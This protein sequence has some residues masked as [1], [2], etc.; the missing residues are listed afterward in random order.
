MLVRLHTHTST[1]SHVEL[2]SCTLNAHYCSFHITFEE[3]ILILQNFVLKLKC[4]LT[5]ALETSWNVVYFIDRTQYISGIVTLTERLTLQTT[6]I[7]KEQH[8]LWSLK[9]S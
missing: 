6:S 5:F 4:V 1:T 2:F 7:C 8:S 9:Y 3:T